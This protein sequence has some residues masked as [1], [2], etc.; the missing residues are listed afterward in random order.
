MDMNIAAQ[1]NRDIA[2]QVNRDLA[3]QINRA[4]AAFFSTAGAE[5]A[6]L[7]DYR[8][9]LFNLVGDFQHAIARPE[10]EI[11]AVRILR[12]ILPCSQAYFSKVESL[13]DKM[14]VAGAAPHR[15]E[16]R[17]IVIDIKAALERYSGT[18]PTPADLAHAL[19]DLVMHEAT[20]R[21]R[22]SAV[23]AQQA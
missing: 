18:K 21:L 14:T 4:A 23:G 2:A 9:Q 1:V 6:S 3:A 5:F 15:S 22:E 16:H 10:G 17:R 8:Q 20:I 13:L 11:R 19:D 12:A 7:T